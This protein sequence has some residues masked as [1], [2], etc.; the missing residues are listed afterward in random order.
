MELGGMIKLPVEL[1]ATEE[2]HMIDGRRTLESEQILMKS[3]QIMLK[4]GKT[5]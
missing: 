5:S 1:R 2:K 3:N 4:S